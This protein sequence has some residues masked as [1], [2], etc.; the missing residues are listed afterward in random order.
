MQ[1]TH[2]P[3]KGTVPALNDVIA[4]HIQVLFGDSPPALPQIAAGKVRALG[5]TTA[6]A[7]RR[8]AATAADQR[9]RGGLRHRA[10]GRC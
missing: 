2:V 8:G 3:Y 1:M 6:Q 7:D 4:G 9:H 5:V 10:P